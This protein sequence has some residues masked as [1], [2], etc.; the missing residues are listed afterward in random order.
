[1]VC[2]LAIFPATRFISPAADVWKSIWLMR[3]AAPIRRR[4]EFPV[5]NMAGQ[6]TNIYTDGTKNDRLIWDF[7]IRIC[8]KA[9]VILRRSRDWKHHWRL[10]VCSLATESHKYGANPAFT[11]HET[12]SVQIR[13]DRTLNLALESGKLDSIMSRYC[14][15][16]QI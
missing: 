8:H 11:P 2:S 1:M 12:K 16:V 6:V 4:R 14:L 15:S 5:C 9:H 7:G 10:P 3:Q 13:Y